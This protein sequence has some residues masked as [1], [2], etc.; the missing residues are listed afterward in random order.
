M[1]SGETCITDDEL[2][3]RW[4]WVVGPS[5]PDLLLLPKPL[6]P[7]PPPPRPSILLP[8]P[9][10]TRK[11]SSFSDFMIMSINP[12]SSIIGGSSVTRDYSGHRQR[13]D[14]SRPN[15]GGSRRG[16]LSIVVRA[17]PNRPPR[18][19]PFPR[20]FC[21]L[22]SLY[23]QPMHY[24][25]PV[26]NRPADPAPSRVC[27]SVCTINPR[28]S[29]GR[30]CP[31]PRPGSRNPPRSSTGSSGSASQDHPRASLARDLRPRPPEPGAQYP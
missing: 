11:A 12:L 4:W 30:Q 1:G 16:G 2:T 26:K 21:A 10:S 19:T 17:R 28:R 9:T 8:I 20:E 18:P 14:E 13:A 29:L 24:A 5:T 7:S 6:P 3:A 31:P 23:K 22:P 15:H 25:Q 27:V